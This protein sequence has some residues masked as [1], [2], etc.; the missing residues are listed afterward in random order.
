MSP[1]S[2]KR[3]QVSLTAFTATPGPRYRAEGPFSGEQWRDEHLLPA[4]ERAKGAGQQLHVSLDGVVGFASSFLEEAF[5]GLVRTTGDSPESVASWLNIQC[6]DEPSAVEA[7]YGK[8]LPDAA[9][10]TVGLSLT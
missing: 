10:G 5:G 8:Y 2:S 1:D 7:I 6:L 9:K 3:H 4:Y